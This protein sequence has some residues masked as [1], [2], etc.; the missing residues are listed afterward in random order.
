MPYLALGHLHE[1]CSSGMRRLHPRVPA[2]RRSQAE[3]KGAALTSSKIWAEIRPSGP[4]EG[5]SSRA[6]SGL[7]ATLSHLPPGH[8]GPRLLPPRLPAPRPDVL[9]PPTIPTPFPPKPPPPAALH[10]ST[11][12]LPLL[13]QFLPSA[14]LELHPRCSSSPSLSPVAGETCRDAHLGRDAHPAPPNSWGRTISPAQRR[15]TLNDLPYQS[16]QVH[17]A[18]LS[19]R[20]KG[21]SW[22]S[23]SLCPAFTGF[24]TV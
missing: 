7:L 5:K 18:S 1:R 20:L 2:S 16:L 22:R 23:L 19:S 24:S 8:C 14:P 13:S 11:P 9:L 15:E 4:G 17:F 10:S 6:S 12:P 3:G 21:K